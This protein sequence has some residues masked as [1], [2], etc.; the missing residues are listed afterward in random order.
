MTEAFGAD[1]GTFSYTE[2]AAG[3]V[4]RMRNLIT[5]Q[6]GTTLARGYATPGVAAAR[7]QQQQVSAGRR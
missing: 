7:T 6:L 3:Y 2:S 1:Y 4:G 5:S